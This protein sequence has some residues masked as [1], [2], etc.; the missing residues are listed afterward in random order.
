MVGEALEG[1][2]TVR[3]VTEVDDVMM[4]AMARLI[5]QLSN[6]SSP[7]DADALKAIVGSDA[8]ILLVAE[9][10]GLEQLVTQLRVPPA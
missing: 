4:A 2:F 10:P 6:S 9:D 7:P 8:S 3:E 1:T 5:P